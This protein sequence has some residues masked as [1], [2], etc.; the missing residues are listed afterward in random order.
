M[1]QGKLPNASRRA[2][3]ELI[4][5]ITGYAGVGK[6][7][8]AD[9]ICEHTDFHKLSFAGKVKELYLRL[10]PTQTLELIEKRGWDF[11]KHH[12]LQVRTALQGLGSACRNTFGKDFWIRQAMPTRL[13]IEHENFV[14]SDVRYANE[15]R[16]IWA[17]DG[18]VIRL[19][20]D[21]V[22]PANAHLSEVGVDEIDADLVIDNHSPHSALSEVLEYIG[23]V[24][25]K[26]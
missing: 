17:L 21:G 11:A 15:A 22:N 25:T 7:T 19:K 4:I 1:A 26:S 9:L 8:L 16:A 3:L 6:D 14:F 20:R 13:E 10:A 2:G 23:W 12:D 18:V 5:G 24:E